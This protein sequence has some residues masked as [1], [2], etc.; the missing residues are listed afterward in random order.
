MK[1]INEVTLISA[2]AFATSSA[3][4]E[5]RVILHEAIGRIEWPAGTG[6]FT[7]YPQSGKKSGEGNGVTPIK[8]GLMLELHERYGWKLEQP[9]S[10]DVEVDPRADAEST[11]PG[12]H[13]ELPIGK[14]RRRKGEKPGK[15]DALFSTSEG[16]VA[17]EWETGNISS[18]HRA[19]NKMA[20]GL[21][22]GVLAAGV[23]VVPTEDFARYLTDRVGNWPELR[24]YFDLWRALPVEE[25][26]L[27]IVAV[28]YDDTSWDVPRILKGTDGRALR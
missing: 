23:L 14:Q 13:P 15:I 6:K 11:D 3:W 18:S 25:G 16:N 4:I 26:V 24:P 27:E 12:T 19:L 2:G 5:T 22:K 17:L 20:L 8:Q 28:E 21:L 7:I 10:F 9:I 1:I